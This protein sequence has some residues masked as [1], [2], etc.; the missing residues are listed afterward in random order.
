MIDS[1]TVDPACTSLCGQILTSAATREPAPMTHSSPTT[2]FSSSST[3]F[4]TVTLRQ[5]SDWRSRELSPMYECGQTTLLDTLSLSSTMTN[6]STTTRPMRN[7]PALILA[8]SPMK[9]GP[10]ILTSTPNST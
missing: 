8:S 5:T 1:C 6:L 10:S 9:A 2:V 4:L 3:L 7:A